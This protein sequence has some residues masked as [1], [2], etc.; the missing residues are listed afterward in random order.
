MYPSRSVDSSGHDADSEVVNCVI[1]H[2]KDLMIATSGIDSDVKSQKT[3]EPPVVTAR[4]MDGLQEDDLI[5]LNVGGTVFTTTRTTITK[6]GNHYFTYLL[7]SRWRQTTPIFIDRNPKVFEYILD[8]LRK[9]KLNFPINLNKLQ[10]ILDEA[11]YFNLDPLIKIVSD[12]IDR[13]RERKLGKELLLLHSASSPSPKHNSILQHSQSRSVLKSFPLPTDSP[14]TSRSQPPMTAR[15]QPPLPTPPDSD[16]LDR[17]LS[18]RSLLNDNP[19]P[20]GTPREHFDL[21]APEFV[22]DAEF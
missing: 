19:T 20:P 14:M 17:S 3:N 13:C 4:L 12:E 8:F 2:P 5:R 18:R 21:G 1:D 11:K 7:D 15:S 10:D 16:E 6:F 22:L 9:G